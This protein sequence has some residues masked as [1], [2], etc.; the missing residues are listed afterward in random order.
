[1]TKDIKRLFQNYLGQ[2]GILKLNGYG[3]DQSISG[4]IKTNSCE[5]NLNNIKILFIVLK[6]PIFKQSKILRIGFN[7]KT[8]RGKQEMGSGAQNSSPH[9]YF[10]QTQKPFKLKNK[11]LS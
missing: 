10:R 9:N 8:T 4:A 6:T 2:G 1:M 5:Y 11:S 3:I 7:K